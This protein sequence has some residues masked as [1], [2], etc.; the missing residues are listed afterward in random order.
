[1]YEVTY[2]KDEVVE[3]P[4]RYVETLNSDGSIDHVPKTGEVLQEGTNQSAT[5]FNHMEHGI[6]D[7]HEIAAEVLRMLMSTRRTLEGLEG[8][9]ITVTLTNSQEYPFNNST[10]TVQLTMPRNSKNYTISP[11]I[12]NVTGGAVGQVDFSDKLLN[13]FKVAFTGSATSVT[14][15]LYVRGGI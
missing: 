10:K 3:H 7:S 14:L 11:E 1:M 15:D 4:Y 6:L 8:E 12:Q 13:G 2:W 9:K 5:N